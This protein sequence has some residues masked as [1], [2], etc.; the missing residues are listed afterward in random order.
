MSVSGEGRM[1]M[2]GDS[3]YRQ[4]GLFD[5]GVSCAIL[6]EKERSSICGEGPA[7]DQLTTG[8]VQSSAQGSSDAHGKNART[9]ALNKRSI[10]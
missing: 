10:A 6:N 9:G 7:V 5:H 8:Y 3:A 2:E 4:R 1:A